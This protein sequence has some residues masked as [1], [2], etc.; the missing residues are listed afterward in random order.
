MRIRLSRVVQMF[1]LSMLTLIMASCASLHPDY[2][3]P[4]VTIS[5]FKVVPQ[6]GVLPTFD[7]G[8]RIINPNP[9]PINLRGVVYSVSIQG[10]ELIKGVGKDYP[11]ID[12]YSQADIAISAVPNMFNGI[13]FITNLVEHPEDHLDYEFNAKLDTGALFSSRVSETGSFDLSGDT[14]RDQP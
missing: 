14:S 8:L 11:Q 6:N 2:E 13:R 4:T 1:V 5:S 9:D 10:Q 7:I 12:G 3:Q